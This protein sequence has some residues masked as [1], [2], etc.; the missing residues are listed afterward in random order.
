MTTD[1]QKQIDNVMEL[2]S[3]Y[4]AKPP[5]EEWMVEVFTG[6]IDYAA[7]MLELSADEVLDYLEEQPL[8]QMAHAHIFEHFITTETNENGET[9]LQAFLRSRVQQ[10]GKSFACQY[11]NALNVA[12]L[13]LWEVISFKAGQS[14]QVRQLGTQHPI[15]QVPLEAERI[16]KN[17]CI[18]SRLLTLP[19]GEHTFSFGLL[20]IERDEADDIL[21]Y[22]EQ[23]RTEMRET[24]QDEGH[25][26]D[27][28]DVED[29][30]HE[31]L[32]DL[33]CHETFVSWISQGFEE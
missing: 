3:A 24:V 12:E 8:G 19:N 32:T 18:A 6:A 33:M 1:Q 22:L 10:D 23:V 21:A 2:L 27:V 4:I 11:L 31:E 14:A 7:E 13:G 28:A 30:I 25:A 15:Y 5:W 16:P 26:K 9:A 20:P 29:A 17:I